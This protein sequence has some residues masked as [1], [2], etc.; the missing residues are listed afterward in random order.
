MK[1][2]REARVVE[3][4]EERAAHLTASNRTEDSLKAVAEALDEIVLSTCT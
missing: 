2:E 3:L 1:E 4:R